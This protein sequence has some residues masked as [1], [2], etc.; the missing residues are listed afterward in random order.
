V[1][2]PFDEHGNLPEG[3]HRAT[4]AEIENRFIE[5]T[6]RRKWLGNRLRELLALAKASGKL[7]RVFLW[8]S[9][10][11]AAEAPGDLDLLL[12]MSPDFSLEQ[13]TQDCKIVFEHVPARLRFNAD[14]FWTRESIGK[15]TLEL[16]LNTYQ[17]T[18]DFKRR[19]IVEV[20]LS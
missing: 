2:P 12:V 1:L 6:P 5:V 14:V 16:W 18:R 19:G 17:T 9:F 20:V 4:E 11:T 15:E 10:V 13:L 7:Q 8:G 3:V